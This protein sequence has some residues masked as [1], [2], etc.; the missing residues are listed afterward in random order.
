MYF[1]QSMWDKS[2]LLSTIDMQCIPIDFQ[3]T[4][5]FLSDLDP[6]RKLSEFSQKILWPNFRYFEIL[7]L[8]S[9][10]SSEYRLFCSENSNL[11]IIFRRTPKLIRK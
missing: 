2:Y 8:Q 9:F 11:E 7:R 10:E 4:P 5:K 1:I 3:K 6:S